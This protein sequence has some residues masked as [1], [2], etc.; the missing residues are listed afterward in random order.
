MEQAACP[1]PPC[2]SSH[3]NTLGVHAS[4]QEGGLPAVHLLLSLTG[5]FQL[6][7]ILVDIP[8]R[9][10]RGGKWGGDPRGL[11]AGLDIEVVM[12]RVQPWRSSIP[13]V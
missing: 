3:P 2:P 7:I 9:C 11:G 12:R 1:S 6:P 4:P 8:A 5:Q 10:G 13:G